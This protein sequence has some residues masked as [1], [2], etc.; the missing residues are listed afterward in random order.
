VVISP[1]GKT[2][3]EASFDKTVKLLGAVG[4]GAE[5]SFL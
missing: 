3:V 4:S 2:L 5:F 1:D